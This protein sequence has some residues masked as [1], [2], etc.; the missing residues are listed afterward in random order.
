MDAQGQDSEAG[1]GS[2]QPGSRTCTLQATH[3]H[4]TVDTKHW[5]LDQGNRVTVSH[6][7]ASQQ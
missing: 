3:E 1:C 4:A 7:K 2:R 6:V 5:A